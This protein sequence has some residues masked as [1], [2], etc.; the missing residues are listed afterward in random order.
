[1]G[2][3]PA[4]PIRASNDFVSGD[5]VYKGGT[6]M[7]FSIS[8]PSN[9][10]T[11][12]YPYF[13]TLY[14]NPTSLEERFQKSKTNAN[15]YGGYIEWIWPDELT[16]VSASSS[17]GAFIGPDSG[18]TSGGSDQPFSGVLKGRKGTIAWERYQDLLEMFRCNGMIYDGNG[19]PAIR[20]SVIMIYDRGVFVGHFSTF[21]DVEDD[22]HPFSFQL[23]WEFKIETAIYKIPVA[24]SSDVEFQAE[25]ELTS[26][27]VR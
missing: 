24:I 27:L 5:F 26:R 1:M 6:P 17:T 21:Q 8:D 16:S 22:E 18:L 12:L 23:T 19:I 14:I 25:N 15:T 3:I 10:L 4:P 20:G 13:L 9:K 11:P 2:K 7:C